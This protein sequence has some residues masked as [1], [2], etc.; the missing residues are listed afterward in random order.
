MALIVF[1]Q[2]S[3]EIVEGYQNCS[4]GSDEISF[5]GVID[6]STVPYSPVGKDYVLNKISAPCSAC[7]PSREYPESQPLEMMVGVSSEQCHS[8][9]II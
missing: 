5:T 4:T 1:S 8:F 6:P 9:W 7:P 2:R 3:T